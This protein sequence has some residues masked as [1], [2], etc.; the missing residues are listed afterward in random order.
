MNGMKEI[1]HK[2]ERMTEWKNKRVDE[3]N[4]EGV[5]WRASE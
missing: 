2:R 3:S 5:N 1:K 4:Y